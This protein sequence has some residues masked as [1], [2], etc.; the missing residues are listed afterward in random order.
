MQY[1]LRKYITGPYTGQYFVEKRVGW[2]PL[3]YWV[4]VSGTS[5]YKE[6]ETLENIVPRK[7]ITVREFDD[8]NINDV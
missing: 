2:G 6:K 4:Y 8:A 3:S 1:R 5:S 7:T